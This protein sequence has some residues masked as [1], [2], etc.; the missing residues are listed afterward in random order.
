M[1]E[2]DYGVGVILKLLTQLGVASDTLVIF[3][4][5]NGGATYAKEMGIIIMLRTVYKWCSC[6]C[7]FNVTFLALIIGLQ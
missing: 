6:Q 5:D 7:V 2:L 1:R 4:S 3:S